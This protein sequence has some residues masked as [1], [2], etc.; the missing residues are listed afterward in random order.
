M[1]RPQVGLG[2][3]RALLQAPERLAG[4]TC[5]FPLTTVNGAMSGPDA[6]LFSFATS[7]VFSTIM[8]LDHDGVWQG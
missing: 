6:C 2:S 4:A 3:L 8:V 1:S 5:D 7:G